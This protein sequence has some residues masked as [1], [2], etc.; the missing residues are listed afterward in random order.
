MNKIAKNKKT[1]LIISAVIMIGCLLLM[2]GAIALIVCGANVVAE[3]L[4]LGIVL[5][6]AGALLAILFAGGIVFGA[7]LFFTGKSLVALNGSIAEENLAKGTVNM[8][9][10]QNC[11]EPVDP[12]DKFCGKCGATTTEFK[13]CENCKVLNKKDANVCTACGE[14]LPR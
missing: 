1:L 7:V 2:G 9:K 10:C 4:A 5:I 6:L 13:Q 8:T 12:A 3:K 14:K 11:G